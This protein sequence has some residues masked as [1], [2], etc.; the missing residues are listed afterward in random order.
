MRNNELDKYNHH[1]RMLARKFIAFAIIAV[2][3]IA[4]LVAHTA[5][6]P[7]YTCPEATII[8]REGDTLW[9]IAETE[10]T[11][12]ITQ[13]ADYLVDKYGTTIHAG[14]A[15]DLPIDDN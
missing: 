12:E 10:C 6:Q 13:V 4:L 11:G 15:I 7:D 2:I 14:Q 5:N 9:S 8:V 1:Y 3:V